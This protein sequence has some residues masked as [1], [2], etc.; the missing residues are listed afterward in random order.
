M[1]VSKLLGGMPRARATDNK[2]TMMVVAFSR[3]GARA[4][5]NIE[6]ADLLSKD[7]SPFKESR[8]LTEHGQWQHFQMGK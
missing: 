1:S 3:H 2:N 4:P 8:E 6:Y 7:G 5:T